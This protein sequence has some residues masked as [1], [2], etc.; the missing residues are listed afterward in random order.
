MTPTNTQKLLFIRRYCE[1]R[2]EMA[3]KATDEWYNNPASPSYVFRSGFIVCD[4][5]SSVYGEDKQAANASFIAA[6][7]T[8]LP[9]AMEMVVEMIDLFT[10]IFEL[11]DESAIVYRTALPLCRK[12]IS[13]FESH[14]GPITKEQ[15]EAL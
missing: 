6:A 13:R 4:C 11:Y 7:R 15:V 12:L 14:H 5:R 2:L 3:G 8:D 9:M 1:K 10:G